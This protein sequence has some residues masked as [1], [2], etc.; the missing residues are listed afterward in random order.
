MECR[1]NLFVFLVLC[2]LITQCSE[3]WS[4]RANAI[5]KETE[6]MVQ[7]LQKQHH[8]QCMMAVTERMADSVDAVMIANALFFHSDTVAAP[9][10]PNAP[11]HTEIQMKKDTDRIAPL[12]HK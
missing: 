6:L 1:N 4:G 11:A 3:D 2:V 12:F 10:R 5:T 9:P 7:F 8:D